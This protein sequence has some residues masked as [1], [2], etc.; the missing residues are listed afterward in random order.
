[1]KRKKSAFEN[2]VLETW[3]SFLGKEEHK[4]YSINHL[5]SQRVKLLRSQCCECGHSR[6]KK[7]VLGRDPWISN[8]GCTAQRWWILSI[9][10][11]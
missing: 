4:N 8:Y 5:I 11:G 6:T 10:E 2:H 1:M 3:P 7:K 9:L